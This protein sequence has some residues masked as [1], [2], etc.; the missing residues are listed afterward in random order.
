MLGWRRDKTHFLVI[1][2]PTST[3]ADAALTAVLD[4]TS[5]F[6]SDV[7]R[8]RVGAT[9]PPDAIDAASGGSVRA[10]GRREDQYTRA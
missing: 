3:R 9:L 10:P 2:H 1:L 6:D 7:P 8:R 5:S 4:L